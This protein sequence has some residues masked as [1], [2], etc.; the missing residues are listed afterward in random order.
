MKNMINY[1]LSFSKLHINDQDEWN[2]SKQN[3]TKMR[4]SKKFSRRDKFQNFV[5]D[6]NK[7]LGT[8][9]LVLHCYL[10]K[11][12]P[13]QT[14]HGHNSVQQHHYVVAE[15]KI[16]SWTSVLLNALQK[17]SASSLCNAWNSIEFIPFPGTDK[18]D[19]PDAKGG[20]PVKTLFR[21]NIYY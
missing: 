19:H 9:T 6:R 21:F 16:Y 20:D 1:W 7:T 10:S 5:W 17:W 12:V 14:S 13:K 3:E 18:I 2:L 15:E 11:C 4:L 8:F